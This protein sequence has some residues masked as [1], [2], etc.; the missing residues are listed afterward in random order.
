MVKVIVGKEY[1]EILGIHILG[2]RAT[3]II[4][5]CA[6]AIGMEATAEDIAAV[7]HA[8][9]TVAEAVRES[10]LAVSKSAIHIPNK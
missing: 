4:A 10:V 1:N 7:I 9:P 6:L 3:D 2:P 8:H 5:E